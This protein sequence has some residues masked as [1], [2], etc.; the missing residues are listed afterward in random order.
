MLFR[1]LLERA[2]GWGL[3]LSSIGGDLKAGTLSTGAVSLVACGSAQQETR[4][5][6]AGVAA[7]AELLRTR[8]IQ[9]TIFFRADAQGFLHAVVVVV[10]IL[11]VCR[12][13]VRVPNQ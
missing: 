4:W 13:L 11:T 5:Q 7:R 12:N 3:A 1:V 8:S 6:I 2:W 9:A 10:P